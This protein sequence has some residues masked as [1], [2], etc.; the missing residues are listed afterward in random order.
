[1]LHHRKGQTVAACPPCHLKEVAMTII[2]LNRY[3]Y[4]ISLE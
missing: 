4:C 3:H 2:N 1:M